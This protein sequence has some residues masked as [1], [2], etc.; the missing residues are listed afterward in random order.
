[1]APAVKQVAS[2]YF[3]RIDAGEFDKG[4]QSTE[5]ETAAQD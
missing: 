4:K 3:A 5:T 1:L 2:A